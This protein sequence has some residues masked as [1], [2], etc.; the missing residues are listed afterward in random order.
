MG[1]ESYSHGNGFVLRMNASELAQSLGQ[2]EDRVKKVM[3][4]GFGEA[5]SRSKD[6]TKR[7]LAKGFSNKATMK[8]GVS[9]NHEIEEEGKD[10]YA[11][12]GSEG[13]DYGGE[14]GFGLMA[15]PDDNG[16]RWN[17]AEQYNDGTKAHWF[18]WDSDGAATFGRQAGKKGG[19]SPWMEVKGGKSY[20]F[21]VV[22]LNFIDYGQKHFEQSVERVVQRHLNREFGEVI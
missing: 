12:F 18:K 22:P 9:L 14:I 2:A 7:Y 6:M 4:R 20:H 21:G 17:I 13:P 15:E 10:I 11:I 3:R 19:D 5:M 1:F 16:D 8:I